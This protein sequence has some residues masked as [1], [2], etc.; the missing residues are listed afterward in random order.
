MKSHIKEKS[1]NFIENEKE[2]HLGFLPTEQPNTKTLT[3]DKAFM[4]STE[5]GVRMLQS[6]DRDIVPMAERIFK[7]AEFL[8]M[9]SAIQDAVLSGHKVVFSGCGATGRLSILLESMWRNFFI[10]LKTE[11]PDAHKLLSKYEDS[12]LSIMTGGDF[13]LVRS[14]ESFEDYQEFGRQQAR[15]MDISSGDVIIAITEGGETSSVLGTVQESISR[16]AAAFLLFNNPAGLLSKHLQRSREAIDHPKVTVLDLYCGP[17][18][19]T[20]STRMQATTSEQLVAGAALESALNEIIR[21]EC[22]SDVAET[23]YIS[24]LVKLLDELEK[25]ETVSGISRYIEFEENIYRNNGLVTYYA[26]DYMLDI[27]TDTTERAPTFMLPPFRRC[28][29]KN[30]QPSWAFVKNP[31]RTTPET[32]EFVL[33]RKPRCLKWEKDDY[34]KMGAE[35]KIV[36]NPPAVSC[37]DISKFLVGNED[38]PSRLSSG[39]NAAVMVLGASEIKN[40][41]FDKI[42]SAFRKIS[43]KYEKQAV[44]VIGGKHEEGKFNLPLK[45]GKSSLELMEH[46]AVKL[47]LNTI[48]TGTMVRLGKVT[49]NWMSFVEVTNKKLLDRGTRIIS[50][51]CGISY[52]QACE[53]LHETLDEFL[54]SPPAVKTSPVQHTIQKIK[55]SAPQ[56][57]SGD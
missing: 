4:S 46:L 1:R 22:A 36:L 28:D 30:S 34:L 19:L 43:G 2:F 31:T 42:E 47:A 8:K 14:V 48:S 37:D 24:E 5:E 38:D 53:K 18:A 10:K 9:K 25:E 21:K 54:S 7:S 44:L 52:E 12:V 49:G 29:D 27:F 16:N 17:M 15:E 3:L 45:I 23:D 40:A 33:G 11:K 20:G 51:L 35:E 32:W 41:D 6:V 13:A 50:S 26:N 55:N 57:Q 56:R 39:L